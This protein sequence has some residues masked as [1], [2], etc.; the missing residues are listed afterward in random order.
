MHDIHQE[1]RIA[2]MDGKT[3]ALCGES[4]SANPFPEQSFFHGA[5]LMGWQDQMVAE[6]EL[7][8]DDF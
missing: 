6:G 8:P 7:A 2:V 5:W 3:A 1:A 4:T